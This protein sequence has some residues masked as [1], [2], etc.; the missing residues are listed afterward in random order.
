MKFGSKSLG[1]S[2]LLSL[3]V[4]TAVAIAM[5]LQNNYD[6]RGRAVTAPLYSCDNCIIGTSRSCTLYSQTG[7]Q[8]CVPSAQCNSST[9][10]NWGVCATIITATKITSGTCNQYCLSHQ[11]S[12]L[13]VGIDS[14]GTNGQIMSYD[15]YGSCVP[16]AGVCVSTVRSLLSGGV[17]C[18]GT[19]PEWTYCRCLKNPY[20]N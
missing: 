1:T 2:L 13:K 10:G 11:G 18:S 20:A 16:R 7:K 5:Q 4:V 6:L 15:N 9:L 3:F 14:N 8:T 19:L 17:K 12:C